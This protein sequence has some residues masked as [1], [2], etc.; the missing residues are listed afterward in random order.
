MIRSQLLCQERQRWRMVQSRFGCVEEHIQRIQA[1]RRKLALCES[2]GW[3]AAGKK[4]LSQVHVVD[5]DIPYYVQE[6]ERSAQACELKVP[7]VAEIYRDLLQAEEE[8]DELRYY[9]EGNLLAV[10]TDAI[11]LRDI[12]LGDFEVQLRI[13]GLAEMRHGHTFRIVALDPHPASSNDSV[14]HPHVSDEQMCAGDA[15]AAINA[16]LIGGRICDFFLLVRSVLTHYNPDSPYVSLDNWDGAACYD[17]GY[18]T[19][20]DS[21]NWCSSCENDF[22]DECASYCRCCE[23]T[24]CLGCLQNCEG[25]DDPVCPSCMTSCPEC[26]RSICKSCL[27][28]VLCPCEEERKEDENEDT[29]EDEQESRQP[30]AVGTEAA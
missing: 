28:E 20:P 7:S 4:L 17:C 13:D 15:G 9:P 27:D 19:S 25:C 3:Y 16:A 5:R 2:R 21:I 23:E 11:E 12:Y 10:S 22:C 30:D 24:T 29:R 8:F 14:T 26:G 18:M 6:A 1:I